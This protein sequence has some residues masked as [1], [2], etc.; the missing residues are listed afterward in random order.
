MR[1]DL[2]PIG[3]CALVAQ[4]CPTLSDPVDCSPPGS[5]VCGILQA[6]VPEWVAIS[7]SRGSSWPRDQ[8]LVSHFAG[9]FVTIWATREANSTSVLIKRGKL[10]REIDMHGRKMKARNTENTKQRWRQKLELCCPKSRNFWGYQRL[11]EA[12][13][14]LIPWVLEEVW[15]CRVALVAHG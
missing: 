14:D 15:S 12:R 9:R 1:V 2:N 7:F 10:D 6:R 13:N 5:S 11:K 4:L 8:T 3:L